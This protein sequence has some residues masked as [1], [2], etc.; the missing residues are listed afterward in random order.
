[1]KKLL[2]LTLALCLMLTAT[3][4]AADSELTQ[5]GTASTTVTYQVDAGY[6][7]TIPASVALSAGSGS[8]TISINPEAILAAGQTVSVA[9]TASA[10]YDATAG[11]RLSDGAATPSYLPY[12]IK[13]ASNEAVAMNSAFVQWTSANL[14]DAQLLLTAGTAA[15]AGNY[16][17]SLT[18][19]VSSAAN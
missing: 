14:S 2:A 13:T 16:T 19:T 6:I 4:F 12:T 10:N 15:V 1:M 5:P 18:F 3:A 17:G 8:L 11:F 9:I 7:V